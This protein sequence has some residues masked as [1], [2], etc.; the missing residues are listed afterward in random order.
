MASCRS[1][2]GARDTRCPTRESRT[3]PDYRALFERGPGLLLVLDPG[4]HIA[5]VSDAYLTATMTRRDDI[6]GRHIFD[7]FPDNP[8]DP[9]A[10]GVANLRASLERVRTL[11]QPDAMA[12]QKYDIRKPDDEGGGY[13]ERFWSPL[14]TPVLDADGKLAWIVHKV[15]DVTELVRLRSADDGA[16]LLA[17]E[18]QGVIERLRLAN[19]ELA[20]TIEENSVSSATASTSPASSN[21]PTTRS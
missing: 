19:R 4:L 20:S 21:G 14:N 18:Q 7:V 2:G 12:V 6:V 5:G 8:D 3:D 16:S 1:S 15:E 17:R 13:E 10:T 11:R 9:G